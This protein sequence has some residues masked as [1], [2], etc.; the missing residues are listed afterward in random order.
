MLYT[1]IRTYIYVYNICI[2]LYT[3]KYIHI[4]ICVYV[5]YVLE[6]R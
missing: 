5:V 1:Y 3:N 6:L 2:L 4:C